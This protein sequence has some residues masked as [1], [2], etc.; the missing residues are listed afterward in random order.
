[1]IRRVVA[2]LLLAG[3]APLAGQRAI[4]HLPV[5]TADL[6]VASDTV[7]G[8]SLIMVPGVGTKQGKKDPA[9]IWLHFHPDSAL[10]WIN[11]AASALR[12]S[13]GADAA[14]G[15]QW[16][17]TLLPRRGRGAI[18]MGRT[19]KKGELQKAHWLAISDSITGWQVELSAQ[20]ADSLL[21]LF[22]MLGSQSRVD[23]SSGQP[24]DSAAV[25]VPVAILEQPSPRFLD[26]RQLGRVVAQYVVDATGRAEPESFVAFVATDP[27][28]IQEFRRVVQNSRF[29]PA[30]RG[31][32]PVRQL[33][34]QSFV[35]L[36]AP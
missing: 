20:Q 24:A 12:V 28:L 26:L 6:T 34:L 22:L 32:R 11:S 31:G 33:V 5:R 29:R 19:R 1:M 27:R 2:L 7:S 3:A 15:I 4:V 30:E 10:D 23:T 17:R 8:L 18:A 13:I 9:V 21:K 25:D 35:V 14:E 16:S 36:P